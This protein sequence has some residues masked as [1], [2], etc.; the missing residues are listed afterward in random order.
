ME[1]LT[2]ST[3]AVDPARSLAFWADE[4]LPKLDAD[5]FDADARD[6]ACRVA[7]RRTRGIAVASAELASYSGIWRE[8]AR[9]I[10]T[11]DSVR[12]FRVKHGLLTL[13]TK[14]G[15]EY[16]VG[17]G[18]VFVSG[19]EAATRYSFAPVAK[20]G[21]AIVADLT[22]IPLA[23]LEEY[24]RYFPPDLARPLP[25]TAT[26]M[27]INTYVAALSSDDTPGSEFMS[28][29]NSFTELF[30]VAMGGYRADLRSQARDSLYYRALA[31]IRAHHANSQL[32]VKR[33]AKALG[34]SERALFAAFDDKDGTPHKYIN[35]VR[36]EAA[37]LL[38]RQS[39]G[40]LS[41]LDV[42]LKCGFDSVSTFN[43]QFRAQA[44]ISP[45]EY[46]AK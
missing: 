12:M 2:L 22:T 15:E 39:D 29:M 10:G 24:A 36:I 26:G 38:L 9:S 14:A 32:T 42:A 34:V 13:K 40:K 16:H 21:T 31:F 20:G 18:S 3:A 6:F 37:R 8:H 19:P 28:L 27:I 5:L 41:M 44:G 17:P 43:R 23:R 7:I 11:A 4:V 46:L 25:R 35:R 33:I 45:S 30:A 1:K